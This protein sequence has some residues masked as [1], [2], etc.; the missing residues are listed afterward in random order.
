MRKLAFTY[1]PAVTTRQYRY[2]ESRWSRRIKQKPVFSNTFETSDNEN[3]YF[4]TI[5]VSLT[6][7]PVTRRQIPKPKLDDQ[8]EF[9]YQKQYK[10]MYS[11]L[12]LNG[13]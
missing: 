11:A 1:T 7:A 6:I 8:T 2:A 4:F 10:R 13:R 12:K 3:D 9:I 5:A